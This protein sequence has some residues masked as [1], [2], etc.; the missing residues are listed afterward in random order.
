MIHRDKNATAVTVGGLQ[1]VAAQPD[2]SMH[3]QITINGTVVTTAEA[4]RLVHELL[5]ILE[6]GR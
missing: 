5:I 2:F 4:Y 6:Q 3:T 1:V